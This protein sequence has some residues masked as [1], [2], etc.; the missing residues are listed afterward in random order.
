MASIIHI[1]DIHIRT[2]SRERSRY[3]EY[4]AVFNNLFRSIDQIKQAQP[5]VIIII[6]GDL[7]HNKNKLEPAGLKIALYLLRGLSDIAP[8][9]LIRGNHDYRQDLPEEDDIISAMLEYSIPG[10][11]YLDKTGKYEIGTIGVGLVAIQDTLLYGAGCGV[12]SVLPAFPDPTSFSSSIKHKLALFH[13]SITHSFLQN[14]HE[15]SESMHGYPIGWFDGYDCILLGDIHLQQVHRATALKSPPIQSD[16]SIQLKEYVSGGQTTWAYPGSIVQQDFGEAILG[17][18]F[19]HWD[20]LEGKVS[21]H[22]IHN[23]F[24]YITLFRGES[25]TSVLHR[26]NGKSRWVTLNSIASLP[27]FPTTLRV[28]VSGKAVSSETLHAIKEELQT[29]GKQTI[30]ISEI[31]PSQLVSIPSDSD[32]GKEKEMPDI[33]QLTSQSTWIQFISDNSSEINRNNMN[34]KEW[35]LHPESLRIPLSGIPEKILKKVNERNEKIIQKTEELHAEIDKALAGP[36][37]SGTV[38]IHYM[39][40]DWLL[41]YKNRNHF[42]FNTHTGSICIFNAKNGYGKSN[43]LEIICI[44][45]YGEGFPSRH[46][47]SYSASI[48]C[49]KKPYGDATGTYI[50]FSV[51]GRKYSIKRRLENKT[52]TNS[53]NIQYSSIVLQ[54]IP[55]KQ[56][57]HQGKPAVDKWISENIGDAETFLMSSM[58][59]QSSDNDFFSASKKEQRD[60]LDRVL[61][62]NPIKSFEELLNES[63]NAHR[64]SCDLLES[65]ASG[66]SSRSISVKDAHEKLAERRTQLNELST[67]KYDL[68]EKWNHIPEK[69][70]KESKDS[71]ETKLMSLEKSIRGSVAPKCSIDH[72][73]EKRFTLKSRLVELDLICPPKSPRSNHPIC[74]SPS[75]QKYTI[76][77]LSEIYSDKNK[78]LVSHPYYKFMS[79]TL[80]RR[81]IHTDETV[82]ANI[83]TIPDTPDIAHLNHLYSTINARQTK[84]IKWSKVF[85]GREHLLARNIATLESAFSEL[86][87]SIKLNSEK[88]D[89]LK[90]CRSEI[91]DKIREVSGNLKGNSLLRPTPPTWDA[92]H[93]TTAIRRCTEVGGK[94]I[95]L[96]KKG[97]LCTVR[98][99]Y[100]R[101]HISLDKICSRVSDLETTISENKKIPFNPKCSTCRTQPWKILTTRLE[102]ELAGLYQDRT[103]V[104]SEIDGLHVGSIDTLTA[105]IQELSDIVSMSDNAIIEQNKQRVFDAWNNIQIDLSSSIT[106]LELEYSLAEKEYN[107]LYRS[108]SDS[109]KS[110]TALSKDIDDISSYWSD[111]NSEGNHISEAEAEAELDNTWIELDYCCHILHS[112]IQFKYNTEYNTISKELE[113]TESDIT[114]TRILDGVIADANHIRSILLARPSWESWQ[115]TVSREKKC[116][117]DITDLERIIRNSADG[118]EAAIMTIRERYTIMD[119]ISKCFKGYR[120]WLYKEKLAPLIQST[121]NTVLRSICQ[122]RPLVLE[123]EWL[124]TIDTLSWFLRDGESRPIIEKASGFQKFITGIAMRVAMSRL[125]ICRVVFSQLFIDEGFTSC[126]SD[127]LERVPGFIRGLLKSYSTIYLATHLETLKSYATS[128]INIERA[129]GLSWLGVGSKMAL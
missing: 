90:M 42:D 97:T 22:H 119:E 128:T 55:E 28:R 100:E 57:I 86:S 63:K 26:I 21:E 118:I 105:E 19:L 107:V 7:F 121:V 129:G 47:V 52:K 46:N 34:W 40:W 25:E 67:Q 62:L 29:L 83:Y 31:S 102:S 64:F 95:A 32:T 10:V 73:S 27:W 122:D 111:M 84:T 93:R 9:Y 48:I 75:F 94:E 78:L 68:S 85:A 61:S 114:N 23:P 127:N 53:R 117:S 14:G 71:L 41:S 30:Q 65:F 80:K 38:C 99:E 116:E 82:P 51:D 50:E 12:S 124:S 115:D 11:H 69:S 66:L 74:P 113:Q 88:L 3:A 33:R 120:A 20:L 123:S 6:T 70:F 4:I 76:N 60:R 56:I 87:V 5:G 112:F 77:Q 15:M 18:G 125:G 54:S 110:R 106:R 16:N 39:E 89:T 1:S 17:H 43:F 72:L 96:A 104:K 91:Y 59:T 13:G 103:A 35:I 44:A 36:L 45:L 92:D 109:E 79:D 101:C 37:I 8:V 58:L 24:G 2:G 108:I 81:S 126:D 98:V 49:D